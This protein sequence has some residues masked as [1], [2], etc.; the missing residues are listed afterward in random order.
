MRNTNLKG[1]ILIFL[2]NMNALSSITAI[3]KKVELIQIFTNGWMEKQ[4]R[5]THTMEQYSTL[6][7][8]ESLPHAYHMG[9]PWDYAKWNKPVTRRQILYDSIYTRFLKESNS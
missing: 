5:S 2:W 7:R 3:V 8:E 9:H 1:K 4:M 6:K